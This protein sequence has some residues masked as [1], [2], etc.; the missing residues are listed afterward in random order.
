MGFTGVRAPDDV[1][2][3]TASGM[4]FDASE[5]TTDDDDNDDGTDNDNDDDGNYGFADDGGARTLIESMAKNH[6]NA[7]LIAS[8][9]RSLNYIAE[10]PALAERMVFELDMVC[11]TV[12]LF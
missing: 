7:D 10:V 11:C 9:L 3:V 12:H 1:D 6:T 2:D 4:Y 8:C 5:L